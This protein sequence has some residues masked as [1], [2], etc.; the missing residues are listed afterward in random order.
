MNIICNKYET[1]EIIKF[2]RDCSE[3]TQSEF[4]KD[5]NKKRGWTAKLEG[6]ITNI[7]LN[8]FI[9][10]AKINDIDII[11]KSNDSIK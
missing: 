5:L 8:D 7:T 6:G 9:K 1:K 3:K 11:M 4:A 10:L 2:M